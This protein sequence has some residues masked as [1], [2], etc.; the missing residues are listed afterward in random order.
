M[1]SVGVTIKDFMTLS[2]LARESG[3]LSWELMSELINKED[4]RRHL[5]TI[6]FEGPRRVKCTS[7]LCRERVPSA[8]GVGAEEFDG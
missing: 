8:N 2:A 4:E 6:P 3:K 7:S 5:E 1:K